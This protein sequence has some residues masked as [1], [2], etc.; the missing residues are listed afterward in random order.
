MTN[1]L[2]LTNARYSF[3]A[4]DEQAMLNFR[5]HKG[6]T[7]SSR[8]GFGTNS[9]EIPLDS[10]QLNLADA[11]QRLNISN[12]L[13]KLL[14]RETLRFLLPTNTYDSNEH[15]ISMH[16]AID[17]DIIPAGYFD[18]SNGTT[19]FVAYTDAGKPKFNIND[20]ATNTI[21]GS[22]P[23]ARATN[24]ARIISTNLP[25]FYTRDA[26]S[27]LAGLT[28]TL[29]ASRLAAAIIDYIDADSNIT[30]GNQGEPAGKELTPH[31]VMVAERNTWESESGGPPYT[32]RIRSEFFVQL[33][34]PYSV[35]VTG[36]ARLEI[37]NRQ[38]L[39]MRNG[40][41]QTD[42]N[43]YTSPL[44]NVSLLPNEIRVFS[45]SQT[46]Q[47]FVNSTTRPSSASTNYPTWPTTS[48]GSSSL[49]GHPQFRIFW[50]NMLM[51]MNRQQPYMA[52]PA[53]AGLVRNTP[54]NTLGLLAQRL[55]CNFC[56]A[57]PPN[58]V[59]DPRA[60]YLVMS[61]W[62]I[63]STLANIMWQGAQQ[64][65]AGRSQ[66][67]NTLWS[68]RDFFRRNITQGSALPTI[69]GTPQSLSSTYNATVGLGAPAY[70][71]NSP[72]VSIGELGNIFDPAQANDSGTSASAGTP[73]SF[74]RPGG[75]RSLRIGRPE[76]SYWDQ[77]RT[78][79]MQ[80]L[81]LFTV[82]SRGTNTN[83]LGT[84]AYTNTPIMQGRVNI[85]TAPRELLSA[86]F[87]R[88]AVNSDLGMP[89]ATNISTNIADAIIANRPYNSIADLSKALPAFVNGTNFS[90]MIT[91]VAGTN[92]M[93]ALDRAREELFRRSINLL[94]TQSRAF[95]IFSIGE[96]LDRKLNT[97]SRASAE[98]SV[99]LVSETNQVPLQTKIIFKK[100]H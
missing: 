48:S 9:A 69:S 82:N 59:G 83:T 74:F 35:Q 25:F 49:T 12:S 98:I 79:A 13:A 36:Q 37:V 16:S 76:N 100:Y 64:D 38:Y 21:F 94:G 68:N 2:G 61:D 66:N 23:E 15:L 53:N 28:N 40:G 4:L 77:P 33:W 19:N 11:N 92:E 71:A 30:L 27:T 5:F 93:T 52:S 70:I 47:D 34:N 8:V 63:L 24:L 54:G 22:S 26:G 73:P 97:V 43:P 87:E 57:N 20:L 99:E 75:G 67:F 55:S 18:N 31:A 3:I 14:S 88:I 89:A 65:V 85:N 91:N 50:N 44:V 17:E 60:N 51:D 29:Y 81:D 96:T 39:E 78:R 10:P 41:A 45:F 42:F 95:R 7:N 86:V 80:L 32:V 58:T 72:M 56:P 90:L 84:S 6:G 46:T 62:T 1:N